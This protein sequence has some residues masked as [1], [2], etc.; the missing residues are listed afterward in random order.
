LNGQQLNWLLAGN[1]CDAHAPAGMVAFFE[2]FLQEHSTSCGTIPRES[3]AM[4]RQPD[5]IDARKSLVADQ[6]V[7][8]ERFAARNEQLESTAPPP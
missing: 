3:I 8:F 2:R 5:D 1:A 7:A 4:D 6:A